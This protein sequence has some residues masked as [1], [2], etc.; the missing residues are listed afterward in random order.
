MSEEL[1][2]PKGSEDLVR[3]GLSGAADPVPRDGEDSQAEPGGGAEGFGDV[4]GGSGSEPG[5]AN[6]AGGVAT[7]DAGNAEG[8]SSSGTAEAEARG[9]NAAAGPA[10]DEEAGTPDNRGLTTDITPSD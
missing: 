8:G 5:T 3:D 2:G 1:S 10:A 7:R 4:P 9:L 6:S